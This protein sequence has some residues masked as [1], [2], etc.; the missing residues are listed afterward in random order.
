[1]TDEEQK[2]WDM[3]AAAALTGVISSEFGHKRMFEHY[4]DKSASEIFSL[5][6]SKHADAMVEQRKERM[7]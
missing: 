4:E 1:M 2:A 7:G 5:F 6:A 3:F